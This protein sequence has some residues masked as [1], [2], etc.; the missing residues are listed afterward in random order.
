MGRGADYT[1]DVPGLP[2]NCRPVRVFQLPFSKWEMEPSGDVM[3][4][5]SLFLLTGAHKLV[6]MD[7][8]RS[9]LNNAWV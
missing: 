1:W 8:E 7:P 9:I 3:T 6:T 2:S 4:D 5:H